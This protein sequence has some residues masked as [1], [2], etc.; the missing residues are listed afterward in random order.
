MLTCG[1]VSS[2]SPAASLKDYSS[3]SKSNA[4][5]WYMN[6]SVFY[7]GHSEADWMFVIFTY[8]KELYV[9]FLFLTLS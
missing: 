1:I 9:S 5:F 7:L 8:T 4:F 2:C 3:T 6:Y